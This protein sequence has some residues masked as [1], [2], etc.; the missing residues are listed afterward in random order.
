MMLL[1]RCVRMVV[2]FRD[3]DLLCVQDKFLVWR[4]GLDEF[5]IDDLLVEV[6][7]S[8]RAEFIRL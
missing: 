8:L 5:F 4:V 1:S 6:F 2:L 7:L 3:G